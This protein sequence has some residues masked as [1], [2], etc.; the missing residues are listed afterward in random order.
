VSVYTV[1][2]H[3][4][5]IDGIFARAAGVNDM[6]LQ[7]DLASHLCVVVSGFV[8]Q[9]TRHIFG[10]YAR[11]KANPHVA[12]YVE[13]QLDGFT[14]ANAAKLCQLS[15]AFKAEWGTDLEAYL[16]G[17]RK[18]ALDSVIANR[19]NI[20]HGRSVGLT[21]V[22]IKEYYEQAQDIVAYLEAQCA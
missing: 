7:A 4:S 8:E 21:Y 5:R 19:H 15:G 20:A 6:E 9:A 12:R 11:T 1:A 10:E 16:E 3:R 13:R 17:Q 14:N 22:R 2:G 18:D